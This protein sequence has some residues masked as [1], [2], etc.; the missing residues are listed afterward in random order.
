M[1]R[2]LNDKTFLTILLRNERQACRIM[3]VVHIVVY[4]FTLLLADL[5]QF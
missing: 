5:V 3:I 4:A 2:A 1:A